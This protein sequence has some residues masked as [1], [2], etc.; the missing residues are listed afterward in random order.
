MNEVRDAIHLDDVLDIL[1]FRDSIKRHCNLLVSIGTWTDPGTPVQKSLEAATTGVKQHPVEEVGGVVEA[2]VSPL[3]HYVSKDSFAVE[4]CEAGDWIWSSPEGLSPAIQTTD[5][6]IIL[7]V[8][9][10]TTEEKS[11]SI[12]DRYRDA[13]EATKKRSKILAVVLLLGGVEAFTLEYQNLCEDVGLRLRR[14]F[15]IY[16]MDHSWIHSLALWMQEEISKEFIY[17]GVSDFCL[18]E[19]GKPGR[20]HNH[21]VVLFI[22]LQ[23]ACLRVNFRVE[24]GVY[25]GVVEHYWQLSFRSRA[26]HILCIRCG[27]FSRAARRDSDE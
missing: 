7:N 6:L 9:L 1:L 26:C 5:H 8:R 18:V 3:L 19:R 22:Q 23:V 20:V 12:H 15:F 2:Q 11:A 16:R 25:D 14:L 21:R 24:V 27:S 4:I 10:E 17:N 13:S